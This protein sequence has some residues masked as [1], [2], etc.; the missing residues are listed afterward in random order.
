MK[1]CQDADGMSIRY[2]AP[3]RTFGRAL[4]MFALALFTWS[5]SACSPQPFTLRPN[6]GVPPPDVSAKAQDGSL[7]FQAQAVVDEDFLYKAFDANPIMAGILP[8]WVTVTNSGEGEADLRKI[9]YSIAHAA[10]AKYKIIEPRKVYKRLISYY[11]IRMYT[12]AGYQQSVDALIS[13]SLDLN[14]PIP[15]GSSRQGYVFF[16]VPPDT[17]RSGDLTLHFGKIKSAGSPSESLEIKLPPAGILPANQS[18]Q[19]EKQ[20]GG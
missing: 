7:A 8:V 4:L 9:D 14:R 17:A 15:T 10:S 19:T 12:K 16:L 3:S 13:M 11:Q 2:P 6:A 1:R 20:D 5:L 18:G